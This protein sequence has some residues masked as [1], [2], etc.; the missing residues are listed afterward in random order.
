MFVECLLTI[1]YSR[2]KKSNDFFIGL[3]SLLKTVL[4]EV[5][6]P[7]KIVL[8]EELMT[9]PLLL[10]QKMKWI[11]INEQ[12]LDYL[13]AKESRIPRTNYGAN[14]Y[15]PFFGILFE[16]NELYYV[17]QVSHPQPRHNGLKQQ[18][19]FYKIFDPKNST[20]LIAVINLN[21]MFPIPKS[22]ALP[23]EKSK[24]HT[25]RIFA[26]EKEKSKYIDLL[27]TELSVINTM[28]IGTKARS[29]YD[30]KCN[31]PKHV[32]SKRCIDFKDMECLA[33]RYK[34]NKDNQDATE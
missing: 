19:D 26:S 16:T 5:T 7:I 24:I 32:V 23:F 11:N 14:K 3:Q 18:K 1:A 2:N 13:R 15:K 4:I 22:E 29:L 8:I 10:E 28:D 20:R 34:G 31:N 27:D 9:A 25:Y 17:T 21:Y 12:Y 33:L 6:K 30:L